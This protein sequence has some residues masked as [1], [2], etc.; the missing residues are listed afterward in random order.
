[1]KPGDLVRFHQWGDLADVNDWSTT[2][3]SKVGVLIEHDKR[4]GHVDILYEG[5]IIRERSAFVEKAG[6][7]DLAREEDELPN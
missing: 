3:K 2:P 5:N 4:F 1:M 7:R 6:K